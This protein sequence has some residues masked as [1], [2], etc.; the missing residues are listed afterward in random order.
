MKDISEHESLAIDNCMIIKNIRQRLKLLLDYVSTLKLEPGQTSVSIEQEHVD[1]IIELKE[2]LVNNPVADLYQEQMN[3]LSELGVG[4]K[5]ETLDLEKILSLLPSIENDDRSLP[6][7]KRDFIKEITYI[8][9]NTE[10]TGTFISHEHLELVLRDLANKRIDLLLDIADVPS[11]E[12]YENALI[13]TAAGYS[14]HMKRDVDEINVNFYNSEWIK[15][16]NGNMDIQLC[17]DYYAIVSYITDYYSKVSDCFS[18]NYNA[19]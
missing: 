19:N 13:L 17:L 10:L 9:G 4:R 6:L 5:Y 1:E 2:I 15:A 18:L 11:Y 12:D 16:W 8:V 14:I 3:I 7:N